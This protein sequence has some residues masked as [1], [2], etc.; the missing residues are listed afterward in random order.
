MKIIKIYEIINNNNRFENPEDAKKV[1]KVMKSVYFTNDIIMDFSSITYILTSAIN[2][3]LG[4][5]IIKYGYENVMKKVSI[6]NIENDNLKYPIALSIKLMNEKYEEEIKSKSIKLYDYFNK[7]ELNNEDGDKLKNQIIE[8]YKMNEVV[9][10]DFGNIAKITE[11]F[12]KNATSELFSKYDKDQLKESIL[13]SNIQNKE[14]SK[15]IE[16]VLYN[17]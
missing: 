16:D 2:H 3:S 4:V 17:K 14:I 9:L 6:S 11:E 8:I 12:F 15:I 13:V 7:N 1:Y 10:L 5:F